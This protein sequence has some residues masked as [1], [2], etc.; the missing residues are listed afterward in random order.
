[1]SRNSN[2]GP[3]RALGELPD[4]ASGS[5]L[6]PG[7]R[8]MPEPAT[9][10][11]SATPRRVAGE[12]A[13]SA[14]SPTDPLEVTAFTPVPPPVPVLPEP[15]AA[16]PPA[17]G[18][19]FSAAEVPSDFVSA[20]PRRSAAS[21]ASPASPISEVDA[22]LPA[23][24]RPVATG[25]RIEPG[26][27][28]EPARKRHRVTT[29]TRA[30]SPAKRSSKPALIVISTVLVFALIV[31]AI[32]YVLTLGSTASS[33]APSAVPTPT[34]LDS[35]LKPTELGDLGGVQWA[36]AS[37]TN[38]PV[39]IPCLAEEP[40]G[41]PTPQRTES[42]RIGAANNGPES[43]SNLVSTFADLSS[44]TQA[45]QLLLTQLGTCAGTTALISGA[46]SIS[47]LAD[48]AQTIN[49][50]IQNEAAE[51]HSVQ[52]T[53]TGRTV[54]LVDVFTTKSAVPA[55]ALARVSV[56]AL[57]RQC[58]GSDG[59]CPSS[60]VV[61]VTPPP[62]AVPQGWLVEADLPLITPG[63]GRWGATDPAATLDVD[64]TQ[65]EGVD[66]NSVSTATSVGQRT[67]LLI[68]DPAAPAGF[69]V[70]QAVL[71]LNSAKAARQLRDK[72]VKNIASCADRVPTA[73]V[74]EGTALKGEG[75]NAAKIDGRAFTV[76]Q[77]TGKDTVRYRVAVLATGNQVVYLL[78]NPGPKFDFSDASWRQL[79]VRA[80]QRVTQGS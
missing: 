26:Q 35:L 68:D 65:C 6:E 16:L 55:E 18:R 63:F 79:A 34:A 31:S 44:A 36:D 74:D 80:G 52:L 10:S 46:N 27:P 4:A 8:Q 62:P 23:L 9:E 42:R 25:A 78:A 43:L 22:A 48:S 29:A 69:G 54:S 17:V 3:R 7:R 40:V 12:M 32:I 66:L 51:Y 64:S 70:D 38:D 30:A 77:T 21:P 56:P 71:K 73:T 15:E 50:V 47:G 37:G 67:F 53:R 14:P 39:Q 61:A 49:L 75:A 57:G 24:S 28:E 60:L 59:A 76:E 20:A 45:Y 19:R 33:G 13:S 72:I 58:T 1:M 2:P 11:A 41:M 5:G